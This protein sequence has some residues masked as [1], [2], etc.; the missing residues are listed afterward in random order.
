MKNNWKEFLYFSK[1]ER[2][3]L[4]MLT[5]LCLI[6]LFSPLIFSYFSKPIP[7]T[8][9]SSFEKEIEQFQQPE[10]V[11]RG[12]IEIAPKPKDPFNFDPN[13]ASKEAFLQLGLSAQVVK[14]LINY[15]NK[16]GRFFKKED[17]QKIYGL[18][19]ATY[20]RLAPFIRI[21]SKAPKQARQNSSP[22]DTSKVVSKNTTR[23]QSFDPNVASQE[24]LASLGLSPKVVRTM[25]NFRS[26]GGSF[27][28]KEDLQKI[29][30]LS[31]EKYQELLPY[32]VIPNQQIIAS[33]SPN[34]FPTKSSTLKIDINQ[35]S[36]EDWQQLNGIG[37]AYAKRIINWRNKLGGFSSTAQIGETFGFPDSV[38]QKIRP[39]LTASPILQKMNINEI[40]TAEL[41]KHPYLNYKQANALIK[42]RENH[43]PYQNLDDLRQLKGLSPTIIDQISPYIAFE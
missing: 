11:L 42:Y 19:T 22:E 9:F 37:P 29:F 43:G 23:L 34:S 20:Q 6:L 24:K 3:G 31:P 17:L 5:F 16:G 1:T 30:G 32:I 7:A 18:D 21:E 2:N 10:P 36:A 26:K 40:Q 12:E 14:N 39:Q 4:A 41:Q 35:A 15:R 13:Q 38:F 27:R 25:I 8:D 33:K 28:K